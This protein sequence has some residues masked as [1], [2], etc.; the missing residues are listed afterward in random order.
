M[1]LSPSSDSLNFP[2]GAIVGQCRYAHLAGE[3]TGRPR[4]SHRLELTRTGRALAPPTSRPASLLAAGG[5]QDR[6]CLPVSVSQVLL[7]QESG[8]NQVW[9]IPSGAAT[10]PILLSSDRERNTETG[11]SLSEAPANRAECRKAIPQRFVLGESITSHCCEDKVID[12]K[13]RSGLLRAKGAVRWEGGRCASIGSCGARLVSGLPLCQC[14]GCAMDGQA[15][16]AA[17]G[18]MK[19]N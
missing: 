15:K 12:L 18:A 2:N 11:S 9:V 14:T 6:L 3:G 4:G 10:P 17:F 16:E 5:A 13:L 19:Y 7:L 8:I 1:E